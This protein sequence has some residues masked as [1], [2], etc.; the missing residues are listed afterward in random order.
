MR[1]LFTGGGTGGHIM[2]LV[3]IS[4]ELRAQDPAG[5]LEMYYIGP[6][7]KYSLFLLQQE[8]IKTC[9]IITGKIRRYFSLVNILDAGFKIP[10]S[11]IESFFLMLFI[12]PKLVF[13]KGGP[14]AY[15]VSWMANLFKIPVFVHESDSIP[16]L[17]N[18][19]TAEF[20]QK[21]FVSFE[22]TKGFGRSKIQVT[23][24]PIRKELLNG[25]IKEGQRLFK[26][27]GEKPI[28]LV[29]GGSQGSEPI[30]NFMLVILED[31]LRSFEIIHISGPKNY[32]DVHLG[33]HVVLERN[34]DFKKYYHLHQSLEEARLKHAYATTDFVISR[35]GAGTIFELAA[36]AKPSILIPL[37]SS[38][39]NHQLENA[40]HYEAAGACLVVEQNNLT[41]NFFLAELSR[42]FYEP[43]TLKKMS[44]AALKFAKPE[45]ASKIAEEIVEYLKS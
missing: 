24:N 8:N 19:K 34:E 5:N 29:M 32:Q 20:A 2:P 17:S 43:K 1:I 9:P 42:L 44:E 35:A 22:N 28:L 7:D 33:S 3:A 30:N 38:A 26:L 14:G 10:I 4:R 45:T 13:S 31:L 36:L 23:G 27:T 41:P 11:F 12:R 16:G 39:S 6:N 37:P 21:I 15:P 25:N 40:Y 18:Q